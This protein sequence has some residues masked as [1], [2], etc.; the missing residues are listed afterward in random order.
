MASG[1]SIGATDITT[2]ESLDDYSLL[3]ILDWVSLRDLLNIASLNARFQ[4]LGSHHYLIG[5]YRL[6]ESELSLSADDDDVSICFNCIET[7]EVL[8][9]ARDYSETMVALRDFGKMFTHLKINI[10]DDGFDYAEAILHS[11][12]KYCAEAYQEIE[13]DRGAGSKTVNIPSINATSVKIIRI[14]D[15]NDVEQFRSDLA[16]PR[17]KKMDISSNIDINHYYPHLIEFAYQP[18]AYES[19][20]YLSD[21]MRLNPQL[22]RIYLPFL[23]Y[24][25]HLTTMNELLPSLESLEFRVGNAE[26]GDSNAV[27]TI[28]FKNV[29]AFTLELG[30]KTGRYWTDQLQQMLSS[31]QFDQLESFDVTNHHIDAID[32]LIE[33]IV[34]NRALA[35]VSLTYRELS[36]QQLSALIAPLT[37]LKVL[38]ITWAHRSTLD[39][40]NAALTDGVT[41]NSVLEQINIEIFE[42]RRDWRQI[43]CENV[44][45]GWHCT[46]TGVMQN[47]IQLHRSI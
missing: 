33:W 20:D 24:G 30:I 46:D 35:T 4:Q 17:M 16:F 7:G 18:I 5:K 13:L 27:E 42:Y 2:L 45:H 41:M 6:H 19:F 37:K 47:P 26:Y 39:E 12:N 36:F 9:L 11:V 32:F 10:Q 31:I 14:S 28:R 34:A 8:T 43:I 15:T 3:S 40:L 23:R 22:H 44:P 21:F 38:T 29:R 1:N 25:S